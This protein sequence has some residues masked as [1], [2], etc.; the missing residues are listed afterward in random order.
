MKKNVGG[1]DRI[2]RAVLGVLIVIWGFYE[3]S[4]WGMLGLV[5]L[6]TA[7]FSWCPLYSLIDFSTAKKR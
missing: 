4:W 6:T 1:A 2:A 7:I 5:M 3:N